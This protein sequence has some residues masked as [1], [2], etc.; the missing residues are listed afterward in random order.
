MEISTVKEG[1]LIIKEGVTAIGERVFEGE[2]MQEIEFPRSLK[3][4]GFSA[5][6]NCK[7]LK[8]V[9]IPDGVTHIG[10]EAFRDC[11][12]LESVSIPTTVEKIE[13]VFCNCPNLRKVV[14]PRHLIS[15]IAMETS[16]EVL[17]F[18][19]E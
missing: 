11:K 2:E 15:K 16:I 19:K 8:E 5:F 12:N 10:S 14:A 17:L 6:A 18:M 4:I 3:L 13:I 7:N 1:K 9:I